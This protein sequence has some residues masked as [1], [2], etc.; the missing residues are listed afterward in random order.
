MT[1]EDI[2]LNINSTIDSIAPGQDANLMRMIGLAIQQVSSN[3]SPQTQDVMKC[4]GDNYAVQLPNDCASVVWVAFRSGNRLQ[5]A[6]R[7]ADNNVI[8]TVMDCE[9]AE[10][11]VFVSRDF[12][13]YRTFFEE[14][15]GANA[16]YFDNHFVY[17]EQYN[18]IV[19]K[20]GDDVKPGKEVYIRYVSTASN[21]PSR[22]FTE[23]EAD[24]ILNLACEKYFKVRNP[25]LAMM[26]HR[27]FL[28]AQLRLQKNRIDSYTPS[29]YAEAL[30]GN[31]NTV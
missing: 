8:N 20:S 16:K 17:E 19:F 31:P 30:F 25:N 14:R 9:G 15:Y 29:E 23:Q 10:T 21:S 6:G 22:N 3:L 12:A 24:V 18:R 26:F 5:K 11:N 7:S 4:I 1:A 13:G 28:A 27:Y 2:L